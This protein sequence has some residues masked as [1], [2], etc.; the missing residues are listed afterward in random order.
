MQGRAYYDGTSQIYKLSVVDDG[1]GQLKGENIS[2]LPNGKV[3]RGP[4]SGFVDYNKKIITFQELRISNL[5]IGQNE[6]DFCF[7]RITGKFNVLENKTILQGSFTSK[8]LSGKACSGGT[9]YLIGEKN[10]TT[11]RSEFLSRLETKKRI[12]LNQ[13]NVKK[14]S[15][16]IVPRDTIQTTIIEAPKLVLNDSSF[17][18]GAPQDAPRFI[19]DNNMLGITLA[20]YHEDDNDRV[21]VFLNDKLILNNYLLTTTG[22]KFD[23]DIKALGNGAG[24]DVIKIACKNEG[25]YSPNSTKITVD[26]GKKKICVTKGLFTGDKLYLILQGG[27]LG[28]N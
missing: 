22:F 27:A 7:F 25:F 1:S 17:L 19:Y 4:V 11:I 28:S 21:D 3:L 6:E 18:G 14:I 10:I 26:D 8:Q 24:L 15:A 12:E 5:P 23:L 2:I 9:I 20:D 13:P 16:K